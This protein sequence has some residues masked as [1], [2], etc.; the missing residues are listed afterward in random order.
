MSNADRIVPTRSANS[1]PIATGY[2]AIAAPAIHSSTYHCRHSSRRAGQIAPLSGREVGE[3]RSG[4]YSITSS[5][6]AKSDG[7]ILRPSIFAVLR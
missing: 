4:A 3:K 6:R 2:S 7:G 1:M 5:A